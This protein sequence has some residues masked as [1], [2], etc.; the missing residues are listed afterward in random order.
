ME[1]EARVLIVEDEESLGKLLCLVLGRHDVRC[2][3]ALDGKQAIDFL[4][5]KD[6]DVLV[7]DLMLPKLSG[8][9]VLQ[10]LDNREEKKPIVFITTAHAD[11]FI[12]RVDP[13]VVTAILRKPYNAHDVADLIR[14]TL[15]AAKGEH[16]ETVRLGQ[17]EMASLRESFEETMRL[18]PQSDLSETGEPGNR[19]ET[20][21][22]SA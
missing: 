15:D 13:D 3:L 12:S 10:F 1:T 20:D 8:Y 9:N 5:R 14:R 18:E 11:D 21:R 22:V 2:D 17:T 16:S 4:V 7:L 19:D 6:Y